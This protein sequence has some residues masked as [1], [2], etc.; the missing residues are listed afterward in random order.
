VSIHF[1]YS[2]ATTTTTTTTTTALTIASYFSTAPPTSKLEVPSEVQQ[3]SVANMPQLCVTAWG[4]IVECSLRTD[5]DI[6]GS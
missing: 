3:H 2:F 4:C 1:E 5:E 6:D